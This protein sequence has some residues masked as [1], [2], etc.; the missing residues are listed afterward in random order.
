MPNNKLTPE[1][2]AQLQ[3]K[4]K[5][6]VAR[7]VQPMRSTNSSSGM[8]SA[9]DNQIIKALG[10]TGKKGQEYALKYAFEKLSPSSV[11]NQ[12][13][14]QQRYDF[15]ESYNPMRLQNMQSNY[16]YTQQANPYKIQQLQNSIRN[17]DQQNWYR[18]NVQPVLNQA[19]L[20]Y[21]GQVTGQNYQLPKYQ[22][23]QQLQMP[24][25]QQMP[26]MQ[27]QQYNMGDDPE[28]WDDETLDAFLNS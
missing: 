7:Q 9:Q 27:T 20:D 10:S 1:Q 6:Q 18:N 28:N 23:Q 21:R 14:R 4:I 24:S 15:N 22:P 11:S 3:A 16:Q 12:M 25:Y 17:S 13:L 26:Q 19:N 2:F 8:L 5:P